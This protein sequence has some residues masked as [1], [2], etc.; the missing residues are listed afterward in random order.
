LNGEIVAG[1]GARK[2]MKIDKDG[3]I[4]T[5]E[6]KGFIS[7]EYKIINSGTIDGA[8]RTQNA[9]DE[10][11]T[12]IQE[13]DSNIAELE[14]DELKYQNELNSSEDKL[15]V[16]EKIRDFTD[17]TAYI[18]EADALDLVKGNL[19]TLVVDDSDANKLSQ[20][21]FDKLASEYRTNVNEKY[22]NQ[23]QPLNIQTI[24]AYLN[25]FVVTDAVLD[26]NGNV[27]Q[28]E[29]KLTDAQITTILSA[30]DVE[31][32]KVQQVAGMDIVLYDNKLVVQ[33]ED[34]YQ[35]RLDK[36]NATINNISETNLRLEETIDGYA[37][38]ISELNS[39]KTAYNDL[40]LH[41]QQNPLESVDV[42]KSAI[43]FANLSY[44]PGKIT[45]TGIKNNEISGTGDFKSYSPNLV[46]DNYSNRDLIFNYINFGSTAT[47]GLNI[48]G[49][50]YNQ[51]AN[52]LK[53]VNSEISE[54]NNVPDTEIGTTVHYVIDGGIPESDRNNL[55][56]NNY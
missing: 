49:K 38:Q 51:Y 20:A 2:Y 52:T 26:A 45:L 40:I 16:L 33:S 53:Q 56:I 1:S 7:D 11:N 25:D 22:N 44:V 6:L 23:D 36:L 14:A 15:E 18:V 55:L 13:I 42:E 31:K 39:E 43:E 10:L 24:E 21:I 47:T 41:L 4:V 48:Y 30:I 5:D 3:N 35:E 54:F 37:T 8:L 27:I 29:V 17:T 34:R 19:N 28:P 46:V 9:I 12:K 50:N 32:Q